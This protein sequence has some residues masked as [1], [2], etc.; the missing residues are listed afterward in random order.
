MRYDEFRYGYLNH[1]CRDCLNKA[2]G[3]SFRPS[4][5]IHEDYPR[6]CS[7]CGDMRHL[8]TGLYGS[9]K[10]RLMLLRPKK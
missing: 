9:G 5:C 10:L 8:I 4:D 3:L 2:T 6:K 1:I 7:Q